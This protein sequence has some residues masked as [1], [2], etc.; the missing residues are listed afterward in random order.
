MTHVMASPWYQ[1][2]QAI[3]IYLSTPVGE[4]TTDSL[5]RDAIAKGQSAA[6]HPRAG[7]RAWPR[8]C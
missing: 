5:V 7:W 4:V 8:A 6:S 3:S 2:A 1:E